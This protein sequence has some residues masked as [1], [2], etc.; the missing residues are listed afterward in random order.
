MVARLDRLSRNVHFIAGLMEHQ[1]HFV[2]ARLGRDCD[3][4]TLHIYASL[5]QQERKLMSER[6]RAAAEVARRRGRKFG[7]ELRSKGWRQQLSV[8]GN[9]VLVQEAMERAT[10]PGTSGMGAAATGSRWRPHLLSRCG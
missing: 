1:L 7:F 4:F 3:D 10:P 8:L 2:V 6:A 9:A 5:A